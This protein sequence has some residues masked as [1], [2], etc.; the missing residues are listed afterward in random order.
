MGSP[1]INQQLFTVDEYLAIERFS[2][3]RHQYLDGSIFAM[4]G[5]SGEHGDICMNISGALF[6]QLKDKSCRARSKDTKVRSGSTPKYPRT[7]SGL[8]SY[9]DIVVICSEPEYVDGYKDIIFNPTV[10]MEVLS[11]TTEEFDRGEKLKRYKLWNPSLQD[12][13]LVSQDQPRIERHSRQAETGW[14]IEIFTGLEASVTLSSIE[15]VVKLADV[16]DRIGFAE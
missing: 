14:S 12:C 8:Y 2:E 10:I 11:P 13:L 5:E 9:P 6:H 15:C 16:Y 4:A 1:K 3:E 7:M